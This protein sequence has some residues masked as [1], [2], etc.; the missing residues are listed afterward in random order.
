MKAN[1]KETSQKVSEMQH[2]YLNLNITS[3]PGGLPLE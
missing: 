2:I 3:N 1:Q